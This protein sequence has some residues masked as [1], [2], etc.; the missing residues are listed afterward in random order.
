MERIVGASRIDWKS[1]P[2]SSAVEQPDQVSNKTFSIPMGHLTAKCKYEM[3]C[4]LC[5]LT[6]ELC[7]LYSKGS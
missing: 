1:Y 3:P 4:G 5:E 6:K 7:T 2:D